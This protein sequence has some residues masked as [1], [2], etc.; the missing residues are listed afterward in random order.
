VRSLGVDLVVERSRLPD[1]NDSHQGLVKSRRVIVKH[2]ELRSVLE[3][4][5][6]ALESDTELDVLHGSVRETFVE[7]PRLKEQLAL[8]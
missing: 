8:E 2:D 4:D 6:E 5:A 7:A 1:A 3:L